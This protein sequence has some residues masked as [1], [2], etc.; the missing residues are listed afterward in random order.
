MYF[1]EFFQYL[2]SLKNVF[3]KGFGFYFYFQLKKLVV[4]KFF[5]NINLTKICTVNHLPSKFR[6]KVM[7]VI[8]NIVSPKYYC[9]IY[10]Y[11]HFDKRNSVWKMWTQ[12]RGKRSALRWIY[13]SLDVPSL[14]PFIYYFTSPVST[15][16][17]LLQ[18]KTKAMLFKIMTKKSLYQVLKISWEIEV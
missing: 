4:L 16:F 13:S 3:A 15:G 18:I 9:A 6:W 2:L 8:Q 10:V 12:G 14:I 11:Y 17:H 5:W 1:V 7:H